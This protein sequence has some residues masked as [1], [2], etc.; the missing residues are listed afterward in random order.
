MHR[1]F[2]LDCVFIKDK[3]KK[4]AVDW[5]PPVC[6][7]WISNIKWKTGIHIQTS[8]G[9]R[10]IKINIYHVIDVLATQY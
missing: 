8:F 6:Y 4:K 10:D 9:N 2:F 5:V 7:I 3:Y 1:F